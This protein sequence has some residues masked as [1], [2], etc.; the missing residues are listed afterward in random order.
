MLVAN[1]RTTI[2]ANGRVV[3]PAEIRRELGL[4]DGDELLIRVEGGRI[5]LETRDELLRRMQ[6]E[7]QAAAGS[8][9]LVDELIAERRLAFEQEERELEQWT[10]PR[11][12]TRR[13]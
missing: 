9:S 8:R 7:F 2:A 13:R 1:G 12:S 10:K 4:E 3:I 5:V 6:A 11:S